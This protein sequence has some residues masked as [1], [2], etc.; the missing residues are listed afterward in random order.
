MIL[1]ILCMEV[2]GH[3]GPIRYLLAP[4]SFQVWTQVLMLVKCLYLPPSVA[5]PIELLKK[6]LLWVQG[7]V[8]G[9]ESRS[10]GM[11]SN[12]STT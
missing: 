2:R 5:D 10:L 9:I 6:G 8:L 3:L 12:Y 7:A 11:L 1:A 4:C